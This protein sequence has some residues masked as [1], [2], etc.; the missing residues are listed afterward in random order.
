VKDVQADEIWGFIG[1]MEGHKRPEE[2]RDETIGDAY[3]FVAMEHNT[4]N[5]QRCLY[6][7]PPL[8]PTPSRHKSD[9]VGVL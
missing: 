3:T 9:D 4:R 8:R 5:W 7:E 2:A 6:A 1:K